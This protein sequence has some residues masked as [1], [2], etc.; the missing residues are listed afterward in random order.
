MSTENQSP[1]ADA[2]CATSSTL[3]CEAL[4]NSCPSASGR[5]LRGD[6]VEILAG[7]ANGC[8]AELGYFPGIIQRFQL[9]E[10]QSAQL[11]ADNAKL[12]ADNRDLAQVVVSQNERLAMFPDIERLQHEIRVLRE[13]R[14]AIVRRDDL[15]L[16]GLT[17]DQ[18][19]QMVCGELQRL[20]RQH[21]SAMDEIVYLRS[22]LARYQKARP[23]PPPVNAKIRSASHSGLNNSEC[24]PSGLS[25]CAK[26]K[27]QFS[28]H[29]RRS[30]YA[31]SYPVRFR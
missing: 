27:S 30:N 4:I 26:G 7:T 2:K 10:A 17:P 12:Y 5:D 9:V 21:Q 14:D 18:G 3:F 28:E 25:H 31:S 8:L 13:E 20:Q 15:I 22:T 1:V 23:A 11:H 29:S 16:R 24:T 6:V 19:Y